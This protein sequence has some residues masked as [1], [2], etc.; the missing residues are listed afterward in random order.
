MITL[1]LPNDNIW[2]RFWQAMGNPDFGRDP[3]FATSEGRHA[4][5]P[6]IVQEITAILRTRGREHWLNLFND[7]QIPAGP[8]NRIDEVTQDP[9][10]LRKGM[11][12]AVETDGE[13]WPQCGLGIDVDGRDCGFRSA[14]PELGQHTDEVLHGLLGYDAE[15]IRRLREQQ[16]I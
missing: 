12:F 15:R 14:P 3:R 16:V 13:P 2:H 11:F 9:E 7:A 1:A 10:L 6:E 5:R 8:I 4:H